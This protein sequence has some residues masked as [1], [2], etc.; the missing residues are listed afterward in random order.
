MAGRDALHELLDTAC[1]AAN[2]ADAV[3]RFMHND[4]KRIVEVAREFFYHSWDLSR[5]AELHDYDCLVTL[6]SAGVRMCPPLFPYAVA[7]R[8]ALKAYREINRYMNVLTGLI[9]IVGLLVLF[10]VLWSATSLHAALAA[11]VVAFV[12]KTFL[13]VR[14]PLPRART[15][16]L[17]GALA[18]AIHY[19]LQRKLYVYVMIDALVV[20]VIFCTV[21][22]LISL[23]FPRQ[24]IQAFPK[25]ARRN[26]T[27]SL[28]A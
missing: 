11:V 26:I 2:P 14:W 3:Q 8:L 19:A 13:F 10:L 12:V 9:H 5:S 21:A 18:I 23:K 28:K 24:I 22:A 20:G 17:A 25:S 15:Y 16:L 4:Q 6:M 1:G 7:I 27:R